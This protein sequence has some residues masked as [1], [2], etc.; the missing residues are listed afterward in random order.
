MATYLVEMTGK[1]AD[2][3]ESCPHQ[4]QW[5]LIT[6]LHIK[7]R[8]SPYSLE[9]FEMQPITVTVIL[10]DVLGCFEG[11]AHGVQ[12][13]PNWTSLDPPTAVQP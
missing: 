2:L 13:N 6:D 8:V 5:G 11:T 9:L 3:E 12:N 10:D 1:R 4:Q 7:P